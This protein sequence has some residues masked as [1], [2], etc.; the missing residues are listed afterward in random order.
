MARRGWFSPKA[1][2]QGIRLEMLEPRL[3]NKLLMLLPSSVAPPA[4]ARAMKMI[5]IAYSVAV[6]P[7]SSRQKRSTIPNMCNFSDKISASAGTALKT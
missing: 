1:S 7:C 3:L 5:N 2:R 4:I 6:A